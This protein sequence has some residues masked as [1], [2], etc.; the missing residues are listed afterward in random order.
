MEGPVNGYSAKIGEPYAHVPVDFP[1]ITL[2]PALVREHEGNPFQLPIQFEEG[3]SSAKYEERL[4]GSRP[5]VTASFGDGYQI[6][7]TFDSARDVL[8]RSTSLSK[9]GAVRYYSVTSHGESS[10]KGIPASV[11]F[12]EGDST[13]PYKTLEVKRATFDEP[14]HESELTLSDIGA[15]F[16]T[17]FTTPT[18]SEYWNGW[19]LVSRQE[20]NMSVYLHGAIPD[21]KIIAT[22]AR[23]T[24]KSPEEW[25]AGHR[26][27]CEAHREAYF[28][29]HGEQPWLW[30]VSKKGKDKDE[31]DVYVEKFI[32]DHKLD[33][34]PAER[35]NEYLDRAKKMR[36]AHYREKRS[37]YREAE[38]DKN[39]KKLE[40]LDKYPKKI[41]DQFLL[42]SLKRL[43]PKEE[44][45]KEE[46]KPG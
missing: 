45:K 32:A 9:N 46:A 2:A 7:W 41:F 44:R 21:A 36:D 10:S 29:K 17:Y 33:K 15:V 19:E 11:T 13:V 3:L 24:K 22:L 40:A 14:W 30:E 31:W 4:E 26:V 43:L 28:K 5:I 12:Y 37:D 18:G 1:A 38:R 25:I 34:K 23:Y 8:P 39:E 6:E 16:G 35:A 42:K 20:Y 27:V